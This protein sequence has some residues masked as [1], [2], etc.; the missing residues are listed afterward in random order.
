MQAS[1]SAIE[2]MNGQFLCGRQISVT[3]AYKKD[4]KV[5]WKKRMSRSTSRDGWLPLG[6]VW[7][8][9]IEGAGG[10]HMAGMG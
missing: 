6:N 10:G 7:A 2:A 4:T 3:Y 5:S 1:D 8:G 9:V